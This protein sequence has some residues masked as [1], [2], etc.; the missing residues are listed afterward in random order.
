M[1]INFTC[2]NFLSFKDNKTLSLLAAS[3]VKEFVED[4]IFEAGRYKLLKS[5]VIYGANAGG[6]SNLLKAMAKMKWLVINMGLRQII[7]K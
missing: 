2:G 6:K 3:T 1:L 4:N 7:K 5:A